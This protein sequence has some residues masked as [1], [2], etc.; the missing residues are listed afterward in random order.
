MNLLINHQIQM[1][2]LSNVNIVNKDPMLN[3]YPRCKNKDHKVMHDYELIII[4]EVNKLHSSQNYE[5]IKHD[6]AIHWTLINEKE[7]RYFIF[8]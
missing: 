8:E 3:S 4:F 2:Y 6:H 5:I 1:F 7:K